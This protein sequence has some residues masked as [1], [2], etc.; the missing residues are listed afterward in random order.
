MQPWRARQRSRSDRPRERLHARARERT[1]AHLHDEIVQRRGA[2]GQH[3]VHQRL[4]A[5]DRQAVLVALAAERQRA[6]AQRLVEAVHAGVAPIAGRARAGDDGRTECVQSLEH[7]RLGIGRDV[8]LQGAR[9]G[10]REHRRGERGVAAA[11]DRQ[12]RPA[13]GLDDRQMEQQAHQVARL[14]RTA[15][16][17]GLVLHP[18]LEA[19]AFA[20]RRLPGERRRA[21]PAAVDAAMR[22]S[23]RRTRSTNAPSLMP[24]A[25]AAC[26]AY[27]HSR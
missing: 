18:D 6:S 16:V 7:G 12:R 27:R 23:M 1:A 5:V 11:G 10:T 20:E 15:D 24:R 8:D 13:A 19:E 22:S 21:K 4:A 14:V 2:T 3:L 26:Q 17:S 9:R 25:R